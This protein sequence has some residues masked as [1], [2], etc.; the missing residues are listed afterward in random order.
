MRS[1]RDDRADGCRP[2]VAI[3]G[4]ASG[5]G[6]A[7]VELFVDRGHD[8]VAVDVDDDGLAA[9]EI[10]TD[11]CRVVGDVADEATNDA[12]VGALGDRRLD[13]LVLNAGIGG[14]RPL[15]APDAVSR[16]DRILAVNVR[17]VALGLR[18]ALPALGP[19]SAV[20]VTA[21]VA[22][23]AADQGTWAYNA[24]KAAVVNL[25]RAAALDLAPRGIRVNAVAPGL[26][27]STLTSGQ[28][29]A[30]LAGR[31]PLGRLAEAR[32]Q[33]EVIGFLASTAASYVTGVTIPCDGGLGAATG[34]LPFEPRLSG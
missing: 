21:S 24:S 27:R 28:D 7:C 4:A 2:V 26:T 29:V 9:L 12:M 3:T 8:V 10:R 16:L 6:R 34:L 25:V 31:I 1:G 30:A 17:G 22:G 15:A 18:A 20:V 11:I 13:V 19:G 23:L 14:T 33:A 5:I 32:E